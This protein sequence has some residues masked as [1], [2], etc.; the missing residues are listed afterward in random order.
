[1]HCF[2]ER[3]SLANWFFQIFPFALKGKI[4]SVFVFD[5]HS[6]VLKSALKIGRYF[7][8][9]V[10][11]FQFRLADVKDE[12]GLLILLRVSLRDLM[13]VQEDILS[14]YPFD[15]VEDHNKSRLP[16]F[17]SKNI[18]KVCRVDRLALNRTLLLIQDCCWKMKMISFGA[19]HCIFFMDRRSWFESIQRYGRRHNVEILP[20]LPR[21]CIDTKKVWIKE[22]YLRIKQIQWFIKYR[23][24]RPLRAIEEK[25]SPLPKVGLEYY[26]Q[27]NLKRPELHSDFFF[28]QASSL[29]P[30]DLLTFFYFQED[31]LDSE[32]LRCLQEEGIRPVVLDPRASKVSSCPPLRLRLEYPL[33]Q[34]LLPRS[35]SNS[36]TRIERKWLKNT[37][38]DYEKQKTH[39]LNV[40][41]NKNVR[42]YLSWFRYDGSHCAIADALQEL[43]GAMAIYQ[44]ALDTT[45]LIDTRINTDI[46]FGYSH[47]V[48]DV[49]KMGQSIIPYFIVTGYLGDHRFVLLKEE[50][51]KV[52]KELMHQGVKKIL[53]YLDEN[54]GPDPRWH[55]GH[56]FMR[57]NYEF[58]LQKVLAH[59]WL[60]L[61]LKPK[62]PSTLRRRLG[63]VNQLLEEAIATGRCYLYEGGKFQGSYPP[64]IAGLSADVTIHGHLCASTAGL[65]SA[66][67]GVPT[68]MMDREGWSVSPLYDLG[69]G[70]VVFK[71]W[72]HLWNSCLEHWKN[73]GG[74]PGFGD[75]SPM[76]DQL[77]PFR[78]GKAAER[79][80]TYLKWMIED[81]KAGCDRKT[82]MTNAAERYCKRWGQDKIVSINA[83]PC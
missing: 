53:A 56:E 75:W 72:D 43:G 20:L 8:I 73:S 16:F 69:V 39:W 19:P 50:A 42:I 47:L 38:N 60:G 82:V 26:G 2:V 44:R 1:M 67:T 23:P 30:K 52:R 40:F 14:H 80:G 74:I 66:L 58:L 49:E 54:S 76:L 29:S 5:A 24:F 31:P 17:V 12:Q 83:Q 48:A 27:F 32:K 46:V 3:L 21:P 61:V 64:A 13:E 11:K 28:L 77:D 78:D 18:M 81:F 33:Q 15:K 35:L 34:K 71:E 65:E 41:S 51:S 68:L 57:V 7:G 59:S 6:F 10:E 22:L 37:V 25:E 9:K 4:K 45:P 79:M 62:T 55:T 63:P 36:L 70:K